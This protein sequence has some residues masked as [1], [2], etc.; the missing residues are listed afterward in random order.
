MTEGNQCYERCIQVNLAVVPEY[1]EDSFTFRRDARSGFLCVTDGC[2]GLGARRYA[3]VNGHTGAYLAARLVADCIGRWEKENQI[4]F[5]QTE[6]EG[7]VLCKELAARLAKEVQRFEAAHVKE[8]GTRI[9]GSMQRAL[10]T[11]LCALLFRHAPKNL[12]DCLFLWAGDSRGYVLNSCGL[13][14]ITADHTGQGMDA[15]TGLYHDAPLQNMINADEPFTISARRLRTESPCVVITAT[16]GAFVYL[17][18]PME[19]EGLLLSA[20]NESSGIE[21]WQKKLE[22][23]L[24]KV[25]SDDCTVLMAMTG[26]ESFE[27][28]KKTME[29]RYVELQREFITPVRRRRQQLDYAQEKWEIY[30]EAYDWTRGKADD[31]LDWR[32]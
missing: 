6:A 24:K 31:G 11:T 22:N 26:Y 17:P 30:R 25:A 15:L 13:H 14:Q 16:D 29:K 7:R 1:G 9:V 4:P 10:P 32:V 12:L 21:M 2:G 28:L 19:F 20:L 18:T 3:D 8:G 5:V 23:M 27:S